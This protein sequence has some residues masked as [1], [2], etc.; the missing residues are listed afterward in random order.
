MAKPSHQRI[1]FPVLRYSEILS[2]A[3]A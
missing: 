2:M 3:W 1:A